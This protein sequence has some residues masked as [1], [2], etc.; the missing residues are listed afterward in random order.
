MIAGY[1]RRNASP[2]RPHDEQEEQKGLQLEV[3]DPVGQRPT[4]PRPAG[5]RQR[6]A[7]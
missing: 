4:Q 5:S 6:Q 2:R 1:N 3:V 7:F